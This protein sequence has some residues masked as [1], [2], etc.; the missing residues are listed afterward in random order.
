MWTIL[1][2]KRNCQKGRAGSAKSSKSDDSA[3]PYGMSQISKV[4]MEEDVIVADSEFTRLHM[5]ISLA[6]MQGVWWM[7]SIADE[8]PARAK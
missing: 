6:L 3:N 5:G 7:M 8:L 4:D 1:A 2:P